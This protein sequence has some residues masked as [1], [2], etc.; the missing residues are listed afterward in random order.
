MQL[1]LKLQGSDVYWV[2]KRSST[3]Q[4]CSFINAIQKFHP[5]SKFLFAVC[6][7]LWPEETCLAGRN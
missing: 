6:W 2:C 3:E 7:V 1:P 5:D 4:N